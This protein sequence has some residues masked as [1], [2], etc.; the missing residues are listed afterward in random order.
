MVQER[1]KKHQWAPLENVT[2]LIWYLTMIISVYLVIF[3]GYNVLQSLSLLTL[4]SLELLDHL[5]FLLMKLN[6]M[7]QILGMPFYHDR[8]LDQDI[9][10]SD[11][12]LLTS[13]IFS[14]CTP[15]TFPSLL[16][17]VVKSGLGVKG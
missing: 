9:Y 17:G 10:S 13:N 2:K 6:F 7:S 14:Y 15:L 11:Q 4:W 5:A 16:Y 3:Y 8:Q 12:H 1:G